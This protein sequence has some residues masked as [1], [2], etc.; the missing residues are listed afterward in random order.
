MEHHPETDELPDLSY[1]NVVGPNGETVGRVVHFVAPGR[2]ANERQRAT[3]PQLLAATIIG[4]DARGP[5][6]M[7]F[8]PRLSD[9]YGLMDAPFSP[10]L[11]EG[12]WSWPARVEKP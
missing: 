12:H 3:P 7:I 2:P 6:L 5:M 9:H 8:S 10:V 11:R 1:L 4:I